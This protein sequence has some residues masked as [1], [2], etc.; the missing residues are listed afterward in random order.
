[1][2]SVKSK[3]N[4][5]SSRMGQLRNQPVP[6][7]CI[8]PTVPRRLLRAH[9]RQMHQDVRE[10]KKMLWHQE[11]LWRCCW[12]QQQGDDYEAENEFGR[13]PRGRHPL[14]L[15]HQDHHVERRQCHQQ[16]QQQLIYDKRT[17]QALP[18]YAIQTLMPGLFCLSKFSGLTGWG[19]SVLNPF[20]YAANSPSLRAALFELTIGKCI[21]IS[22]M[23][24]KCNAIKS[25][26]GSAA[27]R[28]TAGDN[29][30][31][32]DELEVQPRGRHALL[33]IH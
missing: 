6:V 8:Q 25:S 32:K 20:L 17:L 5:C 18:L 1:M 26:C 31:A 14:I 16:W 7:R 21:K 12:Q 33:L 13:Q 4:L 19:N 10:G 15:G 22:N 23:L 29:C 2:E 27:L 11:Q 30:G 3:K 28:A 9:H 24:K